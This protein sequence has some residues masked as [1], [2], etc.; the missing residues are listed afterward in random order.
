MD[1]AVQEKRARFKTYKVLE[2]KGKLTE[3]KEAKAAYMDAKRVA[4]RAVYLAKSVAEKEE[5]A[6]VSPNG[7]GVFRI[8][9]QMDRSNQDVIGENSST[10]C[11][12][13]LVSSQLATRPS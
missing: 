13:M 4:K 1:D 11:A 8:A 7:D 10:V 3:A 5:F 9:K 12:T 2:K 6:T